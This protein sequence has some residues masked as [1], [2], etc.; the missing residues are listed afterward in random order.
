MVEFRRVSDMLF[1]PGIGNV[2]P[3]RIPASEEPVQMLS[4]CSDY[5]GMAAQDLYALLRVVRWLQPKQVFEIGTFQGVTTAHIAANCDARI[6]TLD[7]PRELA[8]GARGYSKSDLA[9]LQPRESIGR[10]CERF[11]R[12]GQIEQLFGDSRTF[13]YSPYWNSMDLVIVDACHLF[14]YVM[15]DSHNAFGLLRAEGVVLWHDFCSSLDVTRAMRVLARDRA[16]HH[17]EGTALAMH[18]RGEAL[19]RSL[20]PAMSMPSLG[21]QESP[22]AGA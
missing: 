13:D 12:K 6:Y 10:A 9:L 3:S 15:S 14:D 11:M 20:T 17:L 7:L 18:V 1:H 8:T 19:N 5:G 4:I 16:I 21:G 22:G 2:T